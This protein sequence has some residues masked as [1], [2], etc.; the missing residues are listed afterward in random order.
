MY[1]QLEVDYYPNEAKKK[2][3]CKLSVNCINRKQLKD[4]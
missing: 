4:S 1:F 2:K 3:I